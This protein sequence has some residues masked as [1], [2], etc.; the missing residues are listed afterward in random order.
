MTEQEVKKVIDKY[1]KRDMF[2]IHGD[3]EISIK[4]KPKFHAFMKFIKW[5][6]GVALN[7]SEIEE[8]YN[9]FMKTYKEQIYEIQ[10]ALR[11]RSI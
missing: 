5:N 3:K 11:S 8:A 2:E 7:D 4:P 10:S 6:Y 9:E 1:A